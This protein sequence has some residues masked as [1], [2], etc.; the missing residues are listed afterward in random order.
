MVNCKLQ[1]HQPDVGVREHETPLSAVAVTANGSVVLPPVIVYVVMLEPE[2]QTGAEGALSTETVTVGGLVFVTVVCA[3][4]E[5]SQ[6]VTPVM[7]ALATAVTVNP[8]GGQPP[9]GLLQ[10]TVAVV[11]LLLTA[12]ME[13]IACCCN[14][15]EHSMLIEPGAV[16]DSWLGHSCV[17]AQCVLSMG[18]RSNSKR[19]SSLRSGI[20]V[21][22]C[23]A[24][25]RI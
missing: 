15:S 16:A 8:P 11:P 12:G 6:P 7:L 14:N 20:P 2:A 18:P 24:H 3:D 13:A 25:S 5:A 4:F 1:R 23:C 21:T 9:S 19:K 17:T 22:S 10:V